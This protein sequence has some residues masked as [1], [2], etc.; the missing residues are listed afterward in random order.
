MHAHFSVLDAHLIDKLEVHAGRSG[1][2]HAEHGTQLYGF[3]DAL[4]PLRGSL[5]SPQF[6]DRI[7]DC[8]RDFAP[9][10]PTFRA[11]VLAPFDL[12][13][14]AIVRF[15]TVQVTLNKGSASVLCLGTSPHDAQRVWDE[16]Q[17]E[18]AGVSEPSDL[19][20]VTALYQEPTPDDYGRTVQVAIDSFGSGFDKV[21]LARSVR[22]KLDG[23]AD[24][25]T[26]LRSMAAREPFCTRYAHHVGNQRFIGASPELLI[27]RSGTHISSQP[28]AGTASAQALVEEL[29]DSNKDN[30]EHRIVVEEIT[31]RLAPYVETLDFPS[32]P[33]VLAL[34]S[35]IHLATRITG[36]LRTPD[37]TVLE[38]LG[39]ICPTPAVSGR[40]VERAIELIESLEHGPRGFFAGAVGWLDAIGNGSFVLA[41]R[42]VLVGNSELLA[43][44]GAGIVADSVA[45]SEIAETEMKLRSILE[46][47]APN[48]TDFLI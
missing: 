8:L 1:V 10:L 28:L 16:F 42:G 24:C 13:D 20:E 19:P 12:R 46:A 44:A 33:E 43:T 5:L 17:A 21:V 3:G 27:R 18:L 39:A 11:H 14:H 48:A 40:P 22:V 4:T 35:V 36:T 6:R 47:A 2:V 7:S 37:T 30:F 25:A 32:Y 26:I 23:N 34:R 15:P 45:A 41:I 38:L 31:S 9:E 29:I